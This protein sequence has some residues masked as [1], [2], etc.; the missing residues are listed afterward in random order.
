MRI[1]YG[2]CWC[3]LTKDCLLMS[4]KTTE[5][6]S[7]TKAQT[8]ASPI[9]DTPPVTIAVFPSNRIHSS[10]LVFGTKAT[11]RIGEPL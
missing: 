5:A 4:K 2:A 10:C 6:P 7:R 8:M 11:A 3:A 9:P 1:L